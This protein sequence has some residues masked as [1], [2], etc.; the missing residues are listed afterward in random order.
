MVNDLLE[1]DH[2]VAVD[3]YDTDGCRVFFVG[4]SVGVRGDGVVDG[5]DIEGEDIG[6]LVYLLRFGIIL[7][8]E[9]A[10]R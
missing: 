6:V 4:V 9:S 2:P 10:Y 5:V 1:I 7:L 8:V 3:A